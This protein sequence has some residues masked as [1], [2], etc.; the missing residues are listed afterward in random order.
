[1]PN[2]QP[3]S[4]IVNA[5]RRHGDA[6]HLYL[7]EHGQF[8]TSGNRQA[9]EQMMEV[10]RRRRMR[11]H[12]GNCF[13]NA[14]RLYCSA[15]EFRYVEGIATVLGHDYADWHAWVVT[16]DGHVADPTWKL[17]GGPGGPSMAIYF[18]MI[19]PAP[20]VRKSHGMQTYRLFEATGVLGLV[21]RTGESKGD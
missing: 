16:P 4:L 17:Y 8:W 7:A 15:P 3:R 21:P 9:H 12:R 20:D 18:G 2:S 14:L 13:I 11:F 1:M 5:L 6:D 19:G 10:R